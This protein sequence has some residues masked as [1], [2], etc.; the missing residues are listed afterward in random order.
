MNHMLGVSLLQSQ[1]ISA[2]CVTTSPGPAGNHPV[3]GGP[4]TLSQVPVDHYGIPQFPLLTSAD[5]WEKSWGPTE[6]NHGEF[7]SQIN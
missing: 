6:V 5:S 4:F 3:E 2:T 7:S 1:G